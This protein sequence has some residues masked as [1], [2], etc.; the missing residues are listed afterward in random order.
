MNWL[1]NINTVKF[2]TT[3]GDEISLRSFKNGISVLHFQI[4][5]PPVCSRNND[6][7]KEEEEVKEEQL[8]V[9]IFENFLPLW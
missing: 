6:D 5:K 4:Q 7:E 8:N 2:Q 3:V 1:R 9:W